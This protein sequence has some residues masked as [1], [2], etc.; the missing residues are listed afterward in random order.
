MCHRTVFACLSTPQHRYTA[1]ALL[2]RARRL[3]SSRKKHSSIRHGL[4]DSRMKSYVFA[5][6]VLFRPP[7][8]CASGKIATTGLSKRASAG[9]ARCTM[10]SLDAWVSRLS[11]L[12]IADSRRKTIPPHGKMENDRFG[13]IVGIRAASLDRRLGVNNSVTRTHSNRSYSAD[14][15][16]FHF[17]KRKPNERW[18]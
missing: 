5:P 15:F 16:H 12:S 6:C 18:S 10:M 1:T 4:I 14:V 8:S 3:V 11:I 7:C 13:P 9:G 2:N 17:V